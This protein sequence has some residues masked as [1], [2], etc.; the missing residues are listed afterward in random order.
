[1]RAQTKAIIASVLVIALALT[2][3]SG[4]TYSWWS[5][6]ESAEITISTGKMDLKISENDMKLTAG[7]EE[8][9]GFVP[10]AGGDGR[11]S[12]SFGIAPPDLAETTRIYTLTYKAVC[13][14]SVDSILVVETKADLDW[15]WVTNVAGQK[16]GATAATGTPYNDDISLGIIKYVKDTD[17]QAGVGTGVT[18]DV[19]VTFVVDLEKSLGKTNGKIE[20]CT[21]LVQEDG[22]DD[23]KKLN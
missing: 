1:M 8:V 19:T 10:I 15:L 22:K 21:T 23:V 6:S 20:L 14:N 16:E 7:T 11:I 17:I 13:T 9:T 18:Y 5:D 3:V 2:A 12:V 4:V